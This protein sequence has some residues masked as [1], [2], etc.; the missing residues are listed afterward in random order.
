M[1]SGK[2]GQ[3][4]LLD[5][6]VVVVSWNVRELLRQ[7]LRS[8]YRSLAEAQ[9]LEVPLCAEVIVVD[10]ASADGSA[11]M[12]LQEFPQARLILNRENRGFTAANNQ[13]LRSAAGR[14]FLLLN[15]DTEV[16][17]DAPQQMV[18]YLDE[19][20]QVAVVGPKLLYPDGQVQP[21][22]RR[23][24]TRA[25]G[26]IESTPLQRA[27]SRS[28]ALQRYY[29]E[30]LPCDREQEVDWVVGAC[31]AVRGE[32]ARQVGFFDESYFMY[33]EELDWCYRLKQAGWKVAYLPSAEVKHYEARSSEQNVLARDLH[34]HE[35][36]CRFY[37]K[38]FGSAFGRFLRLFIMLT[39]VYQLAEESTK[40][41][42]LPRR[43]RE[44]ILRIRHLARVIR[45]QV[46]R[47]L[48][49]F[50]SKKISHCGAMII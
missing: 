35:S 3:E 1:A 43:R 48:V 32:A 25:T 44:R 49:P 36:K 41:I 7:C 42:V 18:S 20:P 10:N 2:P 19:H 31:L 15:P 9:G 22:R 33:S 5:L 30:D 14:Y 13:A 47:L 21:S 38:A 8:V 28:A 34:F 16:L 12:V 4:V 27:F 29:V 11:Q 45:W 50:G 17:G 24:P 40:L 37:E 6:T 26:F 46:R 23:F 39:F